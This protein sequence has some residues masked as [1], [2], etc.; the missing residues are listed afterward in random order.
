MQHEADRNIFRTHMTE[1][2]K[3]CT[4]FCTR[5]NLK[6]LS[7]KYGTTTGHM[8]R[9]L[10]AWW[11]QLH[12][13]LIEWNKIIQGGGGA[14]PQMQIIRISSRTYFF[15]N[16]PLRQTGSGSQLSSTLGPNPGF[17]E[18]FYINSQMYFSV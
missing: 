12:S 18:D 5:L 1:G 17:L 14:E 2:G 3:I 9:G 15:A 11:G 6:K 10:S 16:P 7:S 4:T 13:G 8:K